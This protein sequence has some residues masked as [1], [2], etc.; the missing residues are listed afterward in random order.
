VQSVSFVKTFYR[1]SIVNNNVRHIQRE[2][3]FSYNFFDIIKVL[4]VL[5]WDV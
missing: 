2:T 1:Y 5:F 3:N 4:D